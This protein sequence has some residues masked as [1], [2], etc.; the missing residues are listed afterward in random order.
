MNP[1]QETP[2]PH[3]GDSEILPEIDFQSTKIHL[4]WELW[5]TRVFFSL[6]GVFG[7][8]RKKGVEEGVFVMEQRVGGKERFFVDEWRIRQ[9]D[10]NV[11][12]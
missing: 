9:S 4:K 3:S 7:E 10:G 8:F 12:Y 11:I 6:N 2:L 1:N 5:D